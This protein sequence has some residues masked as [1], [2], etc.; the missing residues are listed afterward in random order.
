MSLALGQTSF[1][2]ALLRALGFTGLFF[3]LGAGA[4]IL[5]RRYIPDLLSP[6]APSSYETGDIFTTASPGSKVNITLDDSS[7]AAVP[8]SDSDT[9][10]TDNVGDFNNLV[11]GKIYQAENP[12]DLDGD[13]DQSFT[14]SYT[15]D[16]EFS[17]AF[18]D[19]GDSDSGEFSMDFGAFV[20][21]SD[22]SDGMDE[23]ITDSFSFF[24]GE[25]E[26]VKAEESAQVR[27]TSS[28]NKNAKLEGDFDAKE[29]ASGIRTVLEKDKKRG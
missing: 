27:R 12:T 7:E 18:D 1:P 3:A 4:G 14:S 10:D 29:I 6:S 20:S 8:E 25:N 16:T 22:E 2:I 15:N 23:S 21:D 26:P 17:Q 28:G 5:I 24:S 11:T 13:I 19:T 9:F